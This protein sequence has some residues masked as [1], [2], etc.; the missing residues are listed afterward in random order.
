MQTNATR[1]ERPPALTTALKAGS[2]EAASMA[3]QLDGD[4]LPED[5]PCPGPSARRVW[6]E[7]RELQLAYQERE[8]G[9]ERMPAQFE[10]LARALASLAALGA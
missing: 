6:S 4:L 1:S 5:C 8:P 3:H 10:W 7:L 9:W 2:W